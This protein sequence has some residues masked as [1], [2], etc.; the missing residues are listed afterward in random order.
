MNSINFGAAQ[1]SPTCQIPNLLHFYAKYFNNVG[2]FV[3]VGAYD[4]QSFSN[5]SVL[6]D[7]GWKG[8]YIEPVSEFAYRCRLRH[9]NNNVSVSN[10]AISDSVGTLQLAVGG[11]L[12]TAS[13]ETRD[14]YKS[15]DWANQL[16]FEDQTRTIECHTLDYFLEHQQVP[17]G[18]ALL[19]VDVEGHE[20]KVFK[21]LS[22]PAWHPKMIIVELNDYHPSFNKFPELQSSSKQL[23][24]SI[25]EFGYMQ[26]YCDEINTIFVLPN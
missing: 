7:S 17:R 12:S 2:T 13:T 4:G 23:R 21:G 19:V 25:L 16:P 22:L 14:A 1:L 24:H 26:A 6:A 9:Q 15:I 10:I 11:V 18:F 8:Y 20:E 3:E 5:T